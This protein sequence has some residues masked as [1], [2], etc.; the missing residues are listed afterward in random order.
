MLQLSG[1]VPMCCGFDS[2]DG[3]SVA[4]MRDAAGAASEVGVCCWCVWCASS[5]GLSYPSKLTLSM[6]SCVVLFWCSSA[7][8]SWL[9]T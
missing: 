2:R 4:V 1:V 9:A 8:S 5:S 7:R 6:S 3:W